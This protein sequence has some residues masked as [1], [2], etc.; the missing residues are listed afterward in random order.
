LPTFKLIWGSPA[1]LTTVIAYS[2]V[3]FMAYSASY[4][5]APYAERVFGVSKSELG[6]L[7][8][9]P[10]AVAGFLGVIFGGVL[11]DWLQ[12]RFGATRVWLILL[13]LL[14]PIA[15][16][17]IQFT[18]QSLEVFYIT[19]VAVGFLAATA[20]GAAAATTQSLVLPRMRA[21]ATA[22]FLLGTTLIGLALGPYMAGLVSAKNADD[23]SLGVLSTTAIAPIGLVAVIAALVLVPKAMATV[24]E[25]AE[26]AGE[27]TVSA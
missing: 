11:S 26:A 5:G 20:L 7:V 15:P 8:G 10:G 19:N 14:A 17:V 13:G 6:F 1:F 12:Q 3:A 2:S 9:A 23:L 4:W 22:T 25:R 21:T 24:I 18:T 27:E 16:L